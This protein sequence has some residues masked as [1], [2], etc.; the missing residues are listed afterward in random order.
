MFSRSPSHTTPTPGSTPKL[1]SFTS[2]SSAQSSENSLYTVSSPFELN[3]IPDESEF[4]LISTNKFNISIKLL[5]KVLYLR[6]EEMQSQYT[7]LR[8]YLCIYV[9]KALR[10][11]DIKLRFDGCLNLKLFP[12]SSHPNPKSPYVKDKSLPIFTQMRSW[13]YKE[14][15]EVLEPDYFSK[16]SFTYPF[17]FLIPNKI[18]ESMSN[19]FG[20]TS[21]LLT[22]IVNPKPSSLASALLTQTHFEKSLPIQIVQCDT[23]SEGS[24]LA[25]TDA[26]SIGNWRNLLY[27]KINISNRQASIG[28]NLKFYIKVIPIDPQRYIFNSI[29]VYLDQ[30]TEYNVGDKLDDLEKDEHHMFLANT[31]R[32]LLD[33]FDVSDLE[34][35]I[36]SWEFDLPLQK[37]YKKFDT[38]K[39]K[40]MDNVSVKLV[41]STNELENRVCHFKVTHKVRVLLSVEEIPL[42]DGFSE[43]DTSDMVSSFSMRSRAQSIDKMLHNTRA[44]KHDDEIIRKTAVLIREPAEKLQKVEL[45]LDAEV[46][47][48]KGES[49]VGKMPPPNYFD[50]S[51]VSKKTPVSNA[52]M[53]TGSNL[54]MRQKPKRKPLTFIV[55]PAYEEIEEL[56]GLPPYIS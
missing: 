5:D 24:S 22:V 4:V 40:V 23:D 11:S 43:V 39:K 29:K 34:N 30:I 17:Q 35:D 47:I 50:S 10:I 51:H 32:V 46:E 14:N 49:V 9:K 44:E 48:L 27:Y 1:S 18:P 45:I 20:S 54:N 41:P 8:G 15:D 53:N 26:L 19:I 13:Q 36:H 21:Y 38:S 7:P 6:G 3:D 16:G 33:E 55:P 52:M 28:N 42:D 25:A 12:S 56:S 2:N 37:D 31:E